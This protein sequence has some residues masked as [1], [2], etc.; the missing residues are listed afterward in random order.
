MI[1]HIYSCRYLNLDIAF[2]HFAFWPDMILKSRLNKLTQCITT[3]GIERSKSMKLVRV[4]AD[5]AIFQ[6]SSA[7]IL[8]VVFPS[9]KFITL[10]YLSLGLNYRFLGNFRS[11]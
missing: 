10:K 7:V 9:K 1:I 8:V 6:V 11:K 5:S 3:Q 4:L 2:K